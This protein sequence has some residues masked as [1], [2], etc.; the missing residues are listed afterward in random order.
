MN[1]LGQSTEDT[2]IPVGLQ[3]RID[4][5]RNNVTVLDA[6]AT[7]LQKVVREETEVINKLAVDKHHLREEIE[8]L[9][10]RVTDTVTDLATKKTQQTLLNDEIDVARAKLLDITLESGVI[11]AKQTAI[12]AALDAREVAI[13][14][15]EEDLNTRN[16]ALTASE[17]RHNAKV[18]KLKAALD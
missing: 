6:E 16:I 8:K 15:N 13:K 10:N 4:N 7:R 11:N 9:E 18:E 2:S 12:S 17:V 1:D 3:S 14:A 5:A